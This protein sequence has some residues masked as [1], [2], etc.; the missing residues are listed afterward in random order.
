MAQT[1]II[2]RFG[3]LTGWN[4][5]TARVFNRNIEAFKEIS[6]GHKQNFANAY[7]AGKYPIGTEETNY[8]TEEGYIDL[9]AEE[10]FAL[11]RSL[12]KGTRL[13]DAPPTEITVGFETGGQVIKDRI[14]NVRFMNSGKTVKQG[15]G[16]IITRV[17][18]HYSHVDED[19]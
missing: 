1:T 2:N 18:I 10:I 9:Y 6:Y 4:S 11:L 5:M 14:N 16:S 13:M 17:K 7:G 8:E 19:I 15:D 12:P 3:K